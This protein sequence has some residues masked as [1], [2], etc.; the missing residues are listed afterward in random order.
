MKNL[1]PIILII[2]SIGLFFFQVKPLLSEVQTLR[3]DS[4]EYDR[5]LEIAD[6]L[7]I[8]RTE[9]NTKRDSFTKADKERL[10]HFLPDRLDTVR[11]IL[12]VDAIGIRNGVRLKDIKVEAKETGGNKATTAGAASRSGYETVTVSFNFTGTY[13]EGTNVIREIE[14]SLRLLDATHVIVRPSGEVKGQ[15]EFVASLSTY[16]LRK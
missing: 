13:A 1:L 6:Q 7:Q 10:D 11:I 16:W 2:V 14:R 12:D 5:A 4:I 3:A 8:L 9:L 15:Y